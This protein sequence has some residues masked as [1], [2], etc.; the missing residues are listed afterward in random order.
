MD[1]FISIDDAAPP[2]HGCFLVFG[3]GP[4]KCQSVASWAH[5]EHFV[6][7]VV[8]GET[9]PLGTSITGT[10]QPL[11]AHATAALDSEMS[12][13]VWVLSWHPFISTQTRSDLCVCLSLSLSLFF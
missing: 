13:V 11:F 8:A 3:G 2:L 10:P 6:P 12:P 1:Q 5:S 4:S 7:A 9:A